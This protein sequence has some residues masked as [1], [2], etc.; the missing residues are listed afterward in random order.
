MIHLTAQF[1]AKMGKEDALYQL[2]T[3]ILAP[4]RNEKGC[5]RYCLFQDQSDSRKFLFQEQFSDKN[6]FDSHCKEA[7][8]TDLI[9]N[10]DGLL[11]EE[12][13][14]TFYDAIEA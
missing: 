2:L 5:I 6:A 9:A 4:T 10:L 7:H 11:E 8:F 13:K 14:I 3:A 1:C 12:P